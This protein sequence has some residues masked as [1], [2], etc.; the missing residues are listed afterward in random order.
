MNASKRG[1]TKIVELLLTRDD[2]DVDFRNKY[3]DT[4]KLS[5]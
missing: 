4:T 5:I 2:I 3:K 1:N